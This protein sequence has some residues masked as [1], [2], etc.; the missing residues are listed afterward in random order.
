MNTNKN[1]K[2]NLKIGTNKWLYTFID[3]AFIFIINER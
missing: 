3:P 2:Q 1:K